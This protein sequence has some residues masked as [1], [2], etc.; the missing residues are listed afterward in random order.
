MTKLDDFVVYTHDKYYEKIL[1]KGSEYRL[2]TDHNAVC[3]AL[4]GEIKTKK[5]EVLGV[6][7]ET[8]GC[9]IWR[10]LG[11]SLDNLTVKMLEKY[12]S[13]LAPNYPEIKNLYLSEV[14]EYTEGRIELKIN[15]ETQFNKTQES[16]ILATPC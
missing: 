11:E 6:G 1:V 10:I 13:D 16:V 14:I 9:E 15:V 2:C 3:Q 5:G 8:F 12:I 4:A 7:L